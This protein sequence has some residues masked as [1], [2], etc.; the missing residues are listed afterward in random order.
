MSVGC[1]Q[2]LRHTRRRGHLQVILE[3]ERIVAMES[4]SSHNRVGATQRFHRDEISRPINAGQSRP[5]ASDAAGAAGSRSNKAIC[6]IGFS[7]CPF[8]ARRSPWAALLRANGFAVP[9]PPMT[10][11]NQISTHN[12]CNSSPVR[13]AHCMVMM[14]KHCA[15]TRH[16]HLG[17]LRAK[18]VRKNLAWMAWLATFLLASS[19]TGHL[20]PRTR[21]RDIVRKIARGYPG[22]G[23]LMNFTRRCAPTSFLAAWLVLVPMLLAQR[24]AGSAGSSAASLIPCTAVAFD[25][26]AEVPGPNCSGARWERCCANI[27]RLN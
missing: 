5:Q 3:S 4:T 23:S 11:V 1:Q 9:V 14:N 24:R 16:I 20:E 10:F 17:P 22:T 2:A 27:C 12:R 8:A 13:A 19:G 18:P 25:L 21:S 15:P 26:S 6:N 7:W